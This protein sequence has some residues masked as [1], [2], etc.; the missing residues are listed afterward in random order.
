MKPIEEK[1]HFQEG[2]VTRLL[3]QRND[4]ER[5][6][7]FVADRFVMT[8]H[9]EVLATFGI[10]EGQLL[11]VAVQ[12]FLYQAEQERQAREAALRYLARRARTTQEIVRYLKHAG[13]DTTLI[14]RVIRYLQAQGYVDDEGYA[15][16]YVRNRL[17]HRGYGPRR[18]RVELQRRGIP[19][20]VIETALAEALRE[21]SPIAIARQV[22]QKRWM[23]LV[24]SEPDILKRRRK[25]LGY[26]QRRGFTL[27]AAYFVLRELS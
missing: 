17:H 9:R 5:F 26:L 16:E 19:P 15:R 18:L 6:S 11:S 13:V 3:P 2:P 25:L 8:L 1:P 27:E 24:Q 22:G 10:Q 14:Q 4:P 23:Q 12:Q 7:L 21:I 20:N